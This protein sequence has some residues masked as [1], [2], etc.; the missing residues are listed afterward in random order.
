L[1]R[2]FTCEINHRGGQ[3]E[4]VKSNLRFISGLPHN[5][6]TLRLIK[7]DYNA[8]EEPLL[9]EYAKSLGID[10][11]VIDGG[12]N[13]RVLDL[14][15]AEASFLDRMNVPKRRIEGICPTISGILPIDFRGD[16]YL[17]C[18]LPNYSFLRIGPYLDIWL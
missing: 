12:G 18:T 8:Q 6:V 1:K 5:K 4:Y 9:G 16:L 15:Y 17:C 13:P 11:E 7:F 3:I 2:G 10:F 14:W